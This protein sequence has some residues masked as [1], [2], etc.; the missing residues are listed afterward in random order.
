MKRAPVVLIICITAACIG[1]GASCWAQTGHVGARS[2]AD[3]AREAVKAGQ[4]EQAVHLYS[5]AI[6]AEPTNYRWLND[7][8]VAYKKLGNI[9]KAVEDYTAALRIQPDYTYAL[10]NRGALYLAEKQYDK[11]VADFTRALDNPRLKAKVFTNRGIA[12]AEQGDHVRAI[13]DFRRAVTHRPLD[14][15]SLVFLAESLEK[16]GETAKALK[17]FRLAAAVVRDSQAL[18]FVEK[19]IA[20]LETALRKRSTG[21]GSPPTTV[22]SWGKPKSAQPASRNADKAEDKTEPASII[23]LRRTC[24]R[25]AAREF[26]DVTASIYGQGVSFKQELQYEQALVRFEDVLQLAKRN[27]N[28]YGIAW[29]NLAIGL[30]LR[31]M[32]EHLRAVPYLESSLRRFVKLDADTEA[33]LVALELAQVSMRTDSKKRAAGFISYAK[34]KAAFIGNATLSGDIERLATGYGALASTSAQSVDSPKLARTSPD[35]TRAANKS[36][37][38]FGDVSEAGSKP[39]AKAGVSQGGSSSGK[40][41]LKALPPLRVKSEEIKTLQKADRRGGSLSVKG[42]TKSPLASDKTSNL[43]QSIRA[44]R[45][46]GDMPGLIKLLE[47]LGKQY[48]T[49]GNTKK[50][51]QSFTTAAAFAE[52]AGITESLGELYLKAAKTASDGDDTSQTLEHY[53]R[54]YHHL[55]GGSETDQAETALKGLRQT[56]GKMGLDPASVK[57]TWTAVWEHAESGNSLAEAKALITLADLLASAG[58]SSAAVSYL[59]RAAALLTESEAVLRERLNDRR[60][61]AALRRQALEKMKTL[62]YPRYLR[63]KKRAGIRSAASLR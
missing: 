61:A 46:A 33:L 55:S 35:D 13:Q 3:R 56:A 34:K 16:T 59:Q 39:A 42:E 38:P 43:I 4:Y 6:T 62:D 60:K 53:A 22:R 18:N 1:M 48:K 10:N 14:Q 44:K 28:R 9:E 27:K 19:R 8:G 40:Q 49:Q 17:M 36:R 7:R 63:M 23:A 57:T 21:T 24:E 12:Y 5:Q 30:T 41:G 25:K 32:G 15:R 58:A 20:D 37:S 29:S 45:E 47:R 2:S 50:A 31:E 54:A 11:A 52:K 26:S 51:V